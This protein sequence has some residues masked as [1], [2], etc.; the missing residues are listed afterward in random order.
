MHSQIQEEKEKFVTEDRMKKLCVVMLVFAFI[1]LLFPGGVADAGARGRYIIGT[2]ADWPPFQWVDGHGNFV[3]FDIDVIRM[4][5]HIA[6]IDIQIKDIAF[7]ALIPS[8]IART[9]DIVVA[10]M[11]ITAERALVVDFSIPYWSADQAVMVRQ[12]SPLTMGTVF[13]D[14]RRIGAQLGTTQAGLLED[15][16][17]NRVD[18]KLVLYDTN[19]LGI[20]DLVLGRIDAFMADTPAAAAFIAVNPIRK[21]G[22]VITGEELGF[23][24]ARG[25]PR[26]ILPRLNAAIIELQRMGVWD[27]LVAAYTTGDLARI[28][29][30]F[31]A[32]RHLLEAGDLLGYAQALYAGLTGE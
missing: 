17:E 20:K 2:S 4:F 8:L 30:V 3:G 12:D 29:E 26:G 18:I 25:D 9:V 28:T 6:G 23:A 21:I 27:V 19:D 13:T 1:T 24:V 15:W 10:G 32:T 31:A 14:R 7:A 22:I 5:A 16:V 11:T